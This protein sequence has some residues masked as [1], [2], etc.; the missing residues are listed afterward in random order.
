M[1]IIHSPHYPQ[2]EKKILFTQMYGILYPKKCKG[3]VKLIQ[4]RATTNHEA[5]ASAMELDAAPLPVSG[6]NK[7]LLE[8][9]LRTCASR[10]GCPLECPISV[11][12]V[13]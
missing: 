6:A 12:N 1:G 4:Y 10:A 5:D 13:Q 3:S 7:R 8:K 2:E 9:Q 11:Q